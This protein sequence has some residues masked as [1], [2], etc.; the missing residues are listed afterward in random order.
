MKIIICLIVFDTEI[1]QSASR[2][3]LLLQ[4]ERFL[5]IVCI[6]RHL[7]HP[8]RVLQASREPLPPEAMS[9]IFEDVK[10]MGVLIGKGGLYG[11][12]MQ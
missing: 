10:D 1:L 12:V 5:I 11:Q 4:V 2:L 8:V 7:T 6:A 3:R 9:E